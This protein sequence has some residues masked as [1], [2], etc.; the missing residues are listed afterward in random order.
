[1]IRSNLY[2]YSN[3]YILFSGT[4]TITVA[5]ANDNGKRLDERNKGVILKNCTPFTNCISEINKI[6]YNDDYSKTSRSLW[7]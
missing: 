1:M 5:G 4:I 3:A 6:E 7:Q 2:D